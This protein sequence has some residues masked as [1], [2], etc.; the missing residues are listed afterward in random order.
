VKGLRRLAD[1]LDELPL[2]VHSSTLEQ[3]WMNEYYASQAHYRTD[4]NQRA[5]LFPFEVRVVDAYFPSPPARL[6]VPGAGAGRELLAL[7]ERGYAVEGLE[8]VAVLRQAAARLGLPL[9]A[10]TVQEW[11]RAPEGRFDGILAGWGLWAH[12]T[13]QA[14]RQAVL[15]A[16]RSVCPSGP[17]LLSFFLRANLH[18]PL[19]RVLSLPLHPE[20]DGRLQRFT[21]GL[22]RARLLGLPPLERGLGWSHG[23][24]FHTTYE[25][26]LNEEAA[27]AGYSVKY[28]E[29]DLRRYAHAVLVPLRRQRR[30]A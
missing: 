9:G 30:R 6:F 2:A 14:E 24:Y 28:F 1:L 23:F 3:R 29:E 22:L 16:F 25:G 18:D 15:E 21:R 19:E 10:Q 26:E 17:V 7:R 11:A 27:K 12:L 13:R 20:P 5:G 8:P 4:L